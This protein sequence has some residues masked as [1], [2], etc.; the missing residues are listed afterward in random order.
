ML[1]NM[2][3]QETSDKMLYS[4]GDAARVLGVSRATV[5]RLG[6]DAVI[7]TVRIGRAIRFSRWALEEFVERLETEASKRR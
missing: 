7:P 4:V 1:V 2:V 6:R 3:E 5:Y